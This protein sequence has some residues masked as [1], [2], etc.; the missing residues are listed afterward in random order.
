METSAPALPQTAAEPPANNRKSSLGL[1]AIL[2][3]F[4]TP[5]FVVTLQALSKYGAKISP[6]A[7]VEVTPNLRLG[8]KSVVSSYVKIKSKD[9]PLHIGNNVEISNFC[10]ITSH[11]GGTYIGD[12]AMIGPNVS[13]IGNNYRYDRLDV[14]IR[15]QEKVSPKG[16]RI[17]NN[18]WI[19]AGCTILDGADIGAGTIVTPNSVVSSKLPENSIAQGNPAKVIFTR[20]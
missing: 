2:R 15:L 13:I 5:G 20:R 8:K 9:G 4:L 19:G 6:K 11:T 16:I 17:G 18:V 3:R 14:P 10:V 7:E 12:D 1:G